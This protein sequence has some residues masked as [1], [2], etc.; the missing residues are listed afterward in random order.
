MRSARARGDKA[1]ADRLFAALVRRRGRCESCGT[2]RHLQC[3]HIHSRRY[4]RVRWDPDNCV[5]L[6]AGCHMY[7]TDNPLEFAAWLQTVRT[8]DQLDELRRRR[9]VGPRPD[10]A[11]LLAAL[12]DA[13]RKGAVW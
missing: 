11:E 3:A 9:D 8:G 10:R 12:E 2:T 4:V 7:Y 13:T 6:C 1:R 5:C